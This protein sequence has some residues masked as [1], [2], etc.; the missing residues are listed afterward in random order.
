M[1][2]INKSYYHINLFINSIIWAET[3]IPNSDLCS[4]LGINDSILKLILSS[5]SRSKSLFH[6]IST[7]SSHSVSERKVIHGFLR[8]YASFWIPPESV[9]IFLLFDCQNYVIDF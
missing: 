4:S 7:V 8:I 2:L 5:I 3:L 6:P 1:I 9:I